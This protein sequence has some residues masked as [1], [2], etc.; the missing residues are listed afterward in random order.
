VGRDLAV[1]RNTTIGGTLNV[2]LGSTL[3]GIVTT[4][5]DLT[6][7][8]DLAVVRNTTIGGTLGVTGATTIGVGPRLT[9][10]VTPAANTARVSGALTVTGASTLQGK[11][12]TQNDLDV[13][14]NLK[15][16]GILGA[17]RIEPLQVG[18]LIT[19]DGGIAVAKDIVVGGVLS[20]LGGN[21]VT[22]NAANVLGNVNIGGNIVAN[23]LQINNLVLNVL[24][25]NQGIAAGFLHIKDN[26]II[27]KDLEVGDE[28]AV[29]GTLITQRIAALN[30]GQLMQ[31]DGG[32]T[33][34]KDLVLGGTLSGLA[35]DPVTINAAK[36]LGNM[37]VA[38][39]LSADGG[40]TAGFLHSSGNVIFDKD[41]EVG[42]ELVVEG[43]LITQRIAAL[44]EGQLMQ[45][46]GGITVTNDLVLGGVLSGAGGNP[47]NIDTANVATDLTVNR[48]VSILNDLLVANDLD[49]FGD[50]TVFGIKFFAQPHPMDS[51]KVI[52]YAALEGPEAGTYVRGTAQ[53]V[54]GEVMIELPE[55]FRLVTSEEGLTAQIT[56]LEEC[57]GLYV[58]EKTPERIVVKELMS[59]SSNARFDYL[60]Q[61]VRKGY[62]DFEPIRDD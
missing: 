2:A 3:T 23:A 41:L 53:L 42:D 57:N 10:T 24:N 31:L 28:L 15:I 7:G 49:V 36:V 4:G 6:V 1:V 18:K 39:D 60:I 44:N 43:T 29:K 32:I 30:E 47:V 17:Q 50:L 19:I 13:G 59:G 46:D 9:F 51:T 8:R 61:G 11:V 35:G 14:R 22:I 56:P 16:Q 55:S 40:V 5:T 27:D 62:E 58:V 25:V 48:D 12:D 37:T 20:G 52:T 34:T 26:A 38:G 54:D 45:L 21:P 33:V